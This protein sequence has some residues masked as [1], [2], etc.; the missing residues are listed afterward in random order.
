MS[1]QG[2]RGIVLKET[3]WDLSHSTLSERFRIVSFFLPVKG[4]SFPCN[5]SWARRMLNFLSEIGGELHL[6]SSGCAQYI[7][8]WNTDPVESGRAWERMRLASRSQ[9]VILI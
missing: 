6:H 3:G 5:T 2:G 4:R 7:K 9:P 8:S 1:P